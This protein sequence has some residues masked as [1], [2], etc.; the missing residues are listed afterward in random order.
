MVA[1]PAP[2]PF[3]MAPLRV[4]EYIRGLA[5]LRDHEVAE[6]DA[7]RIALKLTSGEFGTWAAQYPLLLPVG[8]GGVLLLQVVIIVMLAARREPLAAAATKSGRPVSA[9]LYD[10]S[11][12]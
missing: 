11:R 6:V 9:A 7:E 1:W 8:V 2:P 10:V 5:A 4:R 12:D 3:D